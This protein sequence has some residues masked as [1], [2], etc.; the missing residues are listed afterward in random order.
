[1]GKMAHFQRI[2]GSLLSVGLLACAPPS[3]VEPARSS[4]IVGGTPGQLKYRE[5]ADTT[6]TAFFIHWS[7]DPDAG[8]FYPTLIARKA[9]VV[10]PPALYDGWFD[11]RTQAIQLLLSPSQ[12]DSFMQVVANANGI[13]SYAFSYDPVPGRSVMAIARFCYQDVCLEPASYPKDRSF[14]L[15]LLGTSCL[16]PA[17]AVVGKMS[18]EADD[19]SLLCLAPW[20]P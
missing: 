18:D 13:I 14:D 8:S 3:G 19:G 11:V 5:L 9:G 2:L 15:R 1:M 20:W 16:G 6:S 12:W 17:K 7:G 10:L 4:L